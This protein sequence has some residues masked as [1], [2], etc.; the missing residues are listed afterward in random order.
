LTTQSRKTSYLEAA[1][2]NRQCVTIT[3]SK[4]ICWS[5]GARGSGG[6]RNSCFPVLAR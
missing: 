5:R 6:S 4:H 2:N 3:I 1:R